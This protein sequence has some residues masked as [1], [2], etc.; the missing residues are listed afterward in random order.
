MSSQKNIIIKQVKKKVGGGHH[1]GSWKVAYADFVT[2]MMAFFLLMWLL[3]LTASDPE[4]RAQMA[5]YFNS[6]S[7]FDQGSIS[8]MEGSGGESVILKETEPAEINLSDI[9]PEE[10]H[11]KL[12]DEI[13]SKLEGLEDQLMIEVFSG[14]VR[15][16][17]V[18]KDGQP[19]FPLG[20]SSPTPLGKKML[21]AVAESIKGVPN[22]IAIE[23]H[24]DAL[25][26]SSGK[27][28]NWELSTD[29]A[30]AARKELELS[31]ITPDQLAMVAGYAATS[32]LVKDNPNDPRNRRISIIIQYSG[33]EDKI[34]KTGE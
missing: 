33:G 7:L 24:T 13:Q 9:S 20:G 27:Y 26:Y 21:G 29:R 10:L 11:D 6:F 4:K 32:P 3:S 31:G 34:A 18:D 12:R 30:S 1:G 23:G 15:I 2:G 14:G 17:L 22:K 5:N 19:L 25:S 28:T 16:Q 8:L